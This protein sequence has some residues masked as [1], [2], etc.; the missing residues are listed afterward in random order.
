[1]HRQNSYYSC[2][3]PAT[4]ILTTK[5]NLIQLVK[6][7]QITCKLMR[8]MFFNFEIHNL[9]K[10]NVCFKNMKAKLSLKLIRLIKLFI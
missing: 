3:L 9:L 4:I 6:L 10:T 1:M 8:D 2:R 5:I 7:V